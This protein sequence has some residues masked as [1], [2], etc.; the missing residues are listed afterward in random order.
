MPLFSHFHIQNTK[1][2]APFLSLMRD[3]KS[4][5]LS[6]FPSAFIQLTN[7]LPIILALVVLEFKSKVE[8]NLVVELTCDVAVATF[9]SL[10]LFSWLVT[11]PT[12][13]EMTAQMTIMRMNLIV[14]AVSFWRR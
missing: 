9:E 5:L 11:P 14:L 8:F 4:K 3:F 13:P 2:Y 10:N 6:F 7:I 1:A 12:T